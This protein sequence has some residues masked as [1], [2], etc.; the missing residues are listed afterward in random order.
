MRRLFE[1]LDPVSCCAADCIQ[2]A[3][4]KLDN[5]SRIAGTPAGVQRRSIGLSDQA[6]IVLFFSPASTG[7]LDPSTSDGRVIFFLPW[8]RMT[9]AGTTDSSSELTLEPAPQDRE[10]EFI[11]QEIRNYLSNDISGLIHFYTNI[12][13]R[14]IVLIASRNS[15]ESF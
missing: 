4:K 3:I 10:I 7:L 14:S 9:V 2:L 5:S 15:Y 11:L 12:W 8:E 13:G 1:Q 6:P